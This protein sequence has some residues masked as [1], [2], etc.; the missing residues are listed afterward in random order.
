MFIAAL[1]ITASQWKNSNNECMN[2]MQSLHMMDYYSAVQRI[3]V[4]TR[5]SGTPTH[6]VCGKVSWD[7]HFGGTGNI[8]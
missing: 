3:E 4:L 6:T 1:F 5:A 2:T 7:S 8:Y